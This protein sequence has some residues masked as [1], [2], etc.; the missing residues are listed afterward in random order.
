MS[1][2]VTQPIVASAL[3]DVHAVAKLCDCSTRHVYRL[4]DSGCCPKPVKLGALNRW[5]E[6]TGDPTTGIADWIEAGLPKCR[7][8]SK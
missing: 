4:T 1:A 3:L 7:R 6:R 2:D 8:A 5:R